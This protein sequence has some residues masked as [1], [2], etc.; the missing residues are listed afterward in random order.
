MR[1]HIQ[2]PPDDPAFTITPAL[3]DEAAARAGAVAAGHHVTFAADP[4]GFAAAIGAAEALIGDKD[5]LRP[6]LAAPAL[7][8]RP[9]ALRLV[10]VTNAGLDNLAPFDWLPPGAMLLNNSGTHATKAGEFGLMAVLM[11]ASNIPA[12]VTDQRAGVWRKRWGRSV[13]GERLTVIG[14]GALGAAV[15]SQAAR[16][17]MEVTGVRA[18]PA[19]HPACVRVVGPDALDRVL[20][21]STFLMLAC[22]LTPATRGLLDRR[23]IFLLPRGAGVANIGRGG[24]LDQAALCDAL[25]AGHLSGAVLDVFDPEPIPPGDRAWTTPNLIVSPHTAADDPATYL[26]NSLDIFFNNLCAIAAGQPPP[27]RFD[28]ARGY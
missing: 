2:N 6:L 13:A 24:L 26:P 17:G 27:N 16:L 18:R 21:E 4:A 8:P 3:W 9:P 22:P 28:P 23:R 5:V 1:I 19:P 12:M 25:E 11:L 14:L 20:P 7:S 10:F 15:A